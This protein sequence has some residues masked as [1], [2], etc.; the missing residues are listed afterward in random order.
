M[1]NV[2]NSI[3]SGQS[4]KPSVQSTGSP[5]FT[6]TTQGKVKPLRDKATLL[7]SRIFG[8][9]VE[10][11]KDLK[12]DVVN[13]GRAATGHA[14][15]H[16][17]G[18]INDLAMKVGSL[19]LAAYL[20][21]KVPAHQGKLKKAMEFVGFGTFFGGMALWPKLTIQAPLKMRTGVDIHQKY[22][23]SQGR[24]KM[25]HQDPQ[26]DLTDLY[27]QEDLDKFAKKLKVNENLPDRNRFV[28]QRAKK[29]A[30]QG[31][32]L[33]MMTAGFA[34]PLLSAV[35]CNRLEKPIDKA[36]S[37]YDL[38]STQKTFDRLGK[39]GEVGGISGYI[40][41]LKQKKNAKALEKFFAENGD[42][43]IDDNTTLIK[44]SRILYDDSS[45]K[46]Y[47]DVK[48][49]IK[50]MAEA[51]VQYSKELDEETICDVIAREFKSKSAELEA[52][53]GVDMDEF[54]ET[55]FKDNMSKI[56]EAYDKSKSEVCKAGNTNVI[57]KACED[58]L[59]GMNLGEDLA[60]A[61]D[62]NKDHN[63]ATILREKT[64]VKA[65]YGDLKN[66]FVTLNKLLNDF[67][68]KYNVINRYKLVRTGG[69][70]ISES[71][72]ARIWNQE[73]NAVIKALGFT[74]DELQQLSKH[75]TKDAKKQAK[76]I[77]D[78]KLA[79]LAKGDK[80][81]YDRA[82][83]KISKQIEE[84]EKKL[85]S[86]YCEGVEDQ[87]KYLSGNTEALLKRH[88][89]DDLAQHFNTSTVGTELS[90]T[91]YDLRNQMNGAKSSFY[92]ILETI[93]FYKRCE[94]PEFKTNVKKLMAESDVKDSFT[95]LLKKLN[96]V[97]ANKKCNGLNYEKLGGFIEKLI[98]EVWTGESVK[99]VDDVSTDTVKKLLLETIKPNESELEIP[100]ETLKTFIKSVCEKC[101]NKSG[102]DSDKL[103]EKYVDFIKHFLREG[104]DTNVIEKMHQR[105]FFGLIEE[106]QNI[107]EGH[108]NV[109]MKMLFKSNA[110]ETLDVPEIV[111]KG[112]QDYL[113]SAKALIGKGSTGKAPQN[114]NEQVKN[115]GDMI[116]PDYITGNKEIGK[117]F[118]Q[119]FMD[120]ADKAYNTNKWMKIFGTALAVLTVGTVAATFFIGKKTKMEE[121]VEQEL[122][123]N[124]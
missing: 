101:K 94:A 68:S 89:F 63:I 45:Q 78:E 117:Q 48:N 25:L 121:Q 77:L 110:G 73:A 24:K 93:D 102:D 118:K 76:D 99:K 46:L 55:F 23:D 20:C 27:P 100:Q 53:K 44:L 58:A 82:V 107:T 71:V 36:L 50:K 47:G 15:D 115:F 5:S 37:V 59:Y 108:Y 85:T 8:S 32:T 60:D 67:S 98:A 97:E 2:L 22:Q 18:R 43:V 1:T 28:K 29:V 52:F 62:K 96:E 92:R 12:Q 105:E 119:Y 70:G 90:L 19:A 106:G 14:N 81:K 95:D 80:D 122:K 56:K 31:N 66:K 79:E 109:V 7:P 61:L 87:V 116:E 72:V 84:F 33:W 74:D 9:P 83:S 86:E 13:V 88:G 3:V 6:F 39:T 57:L 10:Y 111:K 49:Q 40:S 11:V 30:V 103:I 16:E 124:G 54:L 34:T 4:V 35:A 42:K 120:A 51:S 65:T 123:L 64:K 113:E 38:K 91:K 41:S 69:D 114:F 21:C 112:F 26:Y 75:Q 104:T 17:L